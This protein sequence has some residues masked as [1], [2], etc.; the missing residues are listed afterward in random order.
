MT[1]YG[2][3]EATVGGR[4]VAI[5]VSSVNRRSLDVTVSLPEGWESLEAAVIERVRRFASRGKIHVEVEAAQAQGAGADWNADEVRAILEKL[6]GFAAA[7]RIPFQPTADLLWAVASSRRQ[8]VAPPGHE[9]AGPALLEGLDVALREFAQMRAKEGETL[10]ADFLS[11]LAVLRRSIEAVAER[12]PKVAPAYRDLLHKR[13][14]E[15]GLELDLNDE[16][17]LKE[18]ALFADRCDVSEEITRFRSHLDQLASLLVSD[19]EIGR[20]AE[21]LLQ[22]LGREAHTLGAKA[23]DLA[24][25]RQVIEL[26]NELERVREQMANVE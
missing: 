7:Q 1:G 18:I 16:R 15:A 17:V 24:I 5:R 6:A 13:L 26:K 9:S 12:A 23:N 22:E 4:S 14:R 21:F 20:K 3:G 19:G 2:R 10:F 8:A 11:R 25:S